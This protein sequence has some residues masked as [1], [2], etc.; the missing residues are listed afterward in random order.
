MKF[1]RTCGVAAAM[2]GA[3]LA[4]SSAMASVNVL[5]NPDAAGPDPTVTVG[6]LDW[7]TGNILA[8]GGV[9]AFNA[10]VT[11]KGTVQLPIQVYAQ[12]RLA[13]FLSPSPSSTPIGGLGLN[14]PGGYEY[15]VVAAYREVIT[16][17]AQGGGVNV[18][19]FGYLPGGEN[20]I[21]VYQDPSRNAN[22]LAGTGFADGN[23]VMSG[24]INGMSPGAGFNAG[25][26]SPVPLDNNGTNNYPLLDTV[27]GQGST[28]VTADNLVVD[29]NYVTLPTAPLMSD[30]TLF[31]NQ[32]LLPFQTTDPSAQFYIGGVE[33]PAG[34]GNPFDPVYGIGP[35]NG[36]SGPSLQIQGDAS[37]NFDMKPI[38]VP[39]PVTASLGLLGLSA[40]GLLA[41]RR[42]TA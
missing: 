17:A 40:L 41:S 30:F 23:L 4:S 27:T 6:G 14:Q 13:N 39:E 3:A 21:K 36:I 22:D 33:T 9:N 35:I 5:W 37:Q 18:A 24:S 26:I 2:L 10:Y 11:S 12:A 29:P 8:V 20:Y 1:S 32:L 7:S 34:A 38:G 42:R 19:T 28:T 15:T 25:T 16:F 31:T